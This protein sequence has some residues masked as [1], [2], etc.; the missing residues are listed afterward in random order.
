[1]TE[2]EDDAIDLV[3]SL[4]E[5]LG[6]VEDE[7]RR[8]GARRAAGRRASSGSS[9]STR[10]S[11]PATGSRSRSGGP[12]AGT[13]SARTASRRVQTTWDAV[14]EVDPEMLLLMPCGFH[15]AETRR[16][17]GAD[18]AAARLRGARRGPPR[19]ASSRSTARPTSA[20][21]GPRVIDGIELLAEIFDPDGF[22]DIAPLG[23]WTPVGP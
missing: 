10:R 3:E 18:A 6:A 13:C 19:A 2:A 9:G 15:L 23:S 8:R 1:M 14:A 21:P 16:R 12:A 7:G 4:R 17:V 5:R 20:G 11:R 22:V